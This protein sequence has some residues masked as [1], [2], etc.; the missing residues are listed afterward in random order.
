MNLDNEFENIISE[1]ECEFESMITSEKRELI[2][3]LTQVWCD[4]K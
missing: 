1:L 4:F 3:Q 2:D